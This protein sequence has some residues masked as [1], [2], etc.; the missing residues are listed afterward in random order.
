MT[1]AEE[2]L[3]KRCGLC[4]HVSI[5]VG[6]SNIVLPGLHCRYLLVEGDKSTCT[7]YDRR[8]EVAY[9]CLDRK[10][11]LERHLMAADCPYHLGFKDSEGK[12]MLHQ[13]LIGEVAKIIIPILLKTGIDDWI[14][15]DGC[16][17]FIE[18]YGYRFIGCEKRGDGRMYIRATKIEKTE[19]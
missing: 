7:V 1:D 10:T 11:A 3:C 6:R 12:I 9:W 13:R 4:C 5:K 18:K 15:L 17:Q 19:K 14:S 8:F 2:D 16:I